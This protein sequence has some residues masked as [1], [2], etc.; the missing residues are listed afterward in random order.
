VF[1]K[2]IDFLI[3]NEPRTQLVTGKTWNKPPINEYV[4]IT[5]KDIFGTW[6]I[7]F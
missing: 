4:I 5:Q 3:F 2:E 6:E 7:K 1:E